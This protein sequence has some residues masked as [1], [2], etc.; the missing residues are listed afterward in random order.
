[1]GVYGIDAARWP[2]FLAPQLTGK[3]QLAFA[4]IPSSDSGDYNAIKRAILSRYD[5]TEGSV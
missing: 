4:A 1:M 5:L 2:Y 3:A